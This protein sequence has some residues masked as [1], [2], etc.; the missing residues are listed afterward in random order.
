MLKESKLSPFWSRGYTKLGA[1]LA[2]AVSALAIGVM[3]DRSDGSFATPS[4][5]DRNDDIVASRNLAS[6]GGARFGQAATDAGH[7]DATSVPRP[8]VSNELVAQ[9]STLQA[10]NGPGLEGRPQRNASRLHSIVG[11]SRDR[12]LGS[13]FGTSSN[14]NGGS[15]VTDLEDFASTPAEPSLTDQP[16]ELAALG[17]VESL[18]TTDEGLSQLVVL[19]QSFV[20]SLPRIDVAVGDYVFAGSVDGE[21][22]DVLVPV[23]EEY[24]LGVSDVQVIGAVDTVD[25]STAH[26]SIGDAVFDYSY[27]LSDIPDLTLNSG[28][29]IQVAGNETTRGGSILLGIHGSGDGSLQGIH[30]SGIGSLQGIHGSGNG[31]LQGIHGSGIGS[32]QG[33]HGSGNGSLQGI[34]GSGNG[35]LQGIHGSGNGSLQGIHGS[36]IGSLQGIHGSGNGSLQGIHGSGNGSLQGIHGSGIGSLQGIHGSGNGSLQGIHGSGIGSLQGI[37]GSGNGS[38]QGIHGSGIGSLQGIHGSGDGS[39]QG[40]H[41]SGDIGLSR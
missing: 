22:L 35:S 15:E 13:V 17:P 23:G 32:L 6:V 25:A 27:F 33:I 2:T 21:Q 8:G 31:S 34:H 10:K 41:G 7:S 29:F 37:H 9:G 3:S 14:S 16:F 40:I 18:S 11:I 4:A 24:L 1:C 28:D 39:L 20:S 26:F 38:L 19:G 30:G 12:A 5:R 36:G